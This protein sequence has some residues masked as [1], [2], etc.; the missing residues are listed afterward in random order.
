ME[1]EFTSEE[2]KAAI[3]KLQKKKEKNADS[4]KL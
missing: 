4:N 1:T 2:V 3:K